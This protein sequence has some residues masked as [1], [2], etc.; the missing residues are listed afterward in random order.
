MDN[1]HI[2]NTAKASTEG[3]LNNCTEPNVSRATDNLFRN[4][5]DFDAL[6]NTIKTENYSLFRDES[7][8]SEDSV[9]IAS[10]DNKNEKQQDQMCEL[11]STSYEKDVNVSE[12]N[13]QELTVKN[14]LDGK[15][16]R[17]HRSSLSTALPIINTL[18]PKSGPHI[19]LECCFKCRMV[20][21]VL[22]RP[23]H[24]RR[25]RSIDKQNEF[26]KIEPSL[27]V[28]SCLCEFCWKYL[29]KSYKY[30]KSKN[31]KEDLCS[32]KKLRLLEGSVKKNVSR[33]HQARRCSIHL[34]PRLYSHKMSVN[35]C[36]HL[37]K[38][39]LTF[40][41]CNLVFVQSRK[42]SRDFLKFPF[43]LCKIHNAMIL[44]MSTCQICGGKLNAPFNSD[45]WSM[46]EMWNF[47]L[48]ENNLPLVLKPP[49]FICVTCKGHIS[50]TN[51]GFPTMELPRLREYILIN[52]EIRLKLYGESQFNLFNICRGSTNVSSPIV[53]SNIQEGKECTRST[54]V[55]FFD[56]SIT[57]TNYNSETYSKEISS[58]CRKKE[59]ECIIVDSDDDTSLDSDCKLIK[60]KFELKPDHEIKMD[61]N[62]TKSITSSLLI[63]EA[64][65]NLCTPILE[66]K[67][68]GL[69]IIL[70]EEE[71]F[72]TH[73]NSFHNLCEVDNIEIVE[74]E[75]GIISSHQGDSE[76][77]NN[78]NEL[79]SHAI[80]SVAQDRSSMDLKEVESPNA[81][82]N[83]VSIKRKQSNVICDTISNKDAKKQILNEKY[84][85]Y[86]NNSTDD[87]I[88][89]SYRNKNI[90]HPSIN[91]PN[92]S[93]DVNE[94]I[95]LN[96]NVPSIHIEE[97]YSL[98]LSCINNNADMLLYL[99]KNSQLLNNRELVVSETADEFSKD[100]LKEQETT[101]YN[102]FGDTKDSIDASKPFT[103][104]SSHLHQ[105]SNQL[106]SDYIEP[107]IIKDIM[108]TSSSPTQSNSIA[109]PKQIFAANEGVG[110]KFNNIRTKQLLPLCNSV[111][112]SQNNII[113][114]NSGSKVPN[115]LLTYT[116]PLLT[117]RIPYLPDDNQDL[118]HLMLP[119][120]TKNDIQF[121]IC[122]KKKNS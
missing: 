122:I 29:E 50:R 71:Y 89:K 36:E 55:K 70:H 9:S 112:K 119:N 41:S 68:K 66:L 30:I 104:P 69:D 74:N 20:F 52:N 23:L 57:I 33:N 118:T 58:G 92:L 113:S 87:N 80:C 65:Q 67:D 26:L 27:F 42:Q 100:Y 16:V 6:V 40:E 12:S 116:K 43:C 90:A 99:K 115:H 109:S 83:P 106:S 7:S 84:S 2:S 117:S 39:F 91:S 82:V 79:N 102:C 62:D 1:R 3:I 18:S 4:E 85:S 88:T 19:C 105:Y 94:D 86:D 110:S 25:I 120:L 64:E 22:D 49:M 73:D 95:Q 17:L 32:E 63:N 77:E 48:T 72:K 121:P 45:D 44:V 51:P 59:T 81:I 10:I 101:L 78:Q 5:K 47:V 28:D 8:D 107:L 75:S 38:L 96:T 98:D 56:P 11:A 111:S 14:L 13:S 114:T 108:T 21:R 103:H 15:I 97:D 24:I 35:E 76:I 61:K 54:K 53:V 34:C 37:K 93:I 60:S 31:R 46:H